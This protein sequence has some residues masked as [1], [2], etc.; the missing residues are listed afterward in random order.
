M[1]TLVGNLLQ[2]SRRSHA[3][4]STLDIREE[5]TDSID[6]IHYHLRSRKVKV[7][8][9]FADKLPAV[10]G[11]RQRLRQV[12][13]NLLTN[14]T[15][16][17][18]EGGTLTLRVHAEVLDSNAGMV[19]VQFI[20]TGMGI[21]PDQLQQIWEPF[22]TTKPEGKGTGLGLPICRRTIEEHRG[23]IDVQSEPNQGTKIRIHLPLNNA[24]PFET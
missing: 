5:L 10:Q 7:V 16:A 8:R 22:F 4:I 19:I 14:A 11:D 1:A 6:L 3:Q 23:T 2:F 20:D 21:H 12:F 17:M 15:D 18:P 13:L 24:T 9:E